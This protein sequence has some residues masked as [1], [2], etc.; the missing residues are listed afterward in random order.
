MARN[1]LEAV[2]GAL[3]GG[4]VG[5]GKDKNLR[6]DREEE[7]L[8][9]E[10]AARQREEQ[11]RLDLFNAGL[12]EETSLRKRPAT[13]RTAGAAAQAIP[14]SGTIGSAL[15]VASRQMDSNI[16]GGRRITLSDGTTY[17]QPYDR[18]PQGLAEA[19]TKQAAQMYERSRADALADA[20][21]AFE[22]DRTLTEMR[23][24]GALAVA[25][26]RDNAQAGGGGT[27]SG[28]GR[29]GVDM[30][31]LPT[32]VRAADDVAKLTREQI[33]GMDPS[34]V[35]A[36]SMA[37]L[38]AAEPSL[39]NLA[40]AGV[41]NL[42]ANRGGI[43]TGS[44]S[45][46]EPLYAQYIGGVSDAIARIGERVGVM[47]NQ[48]IARYRALTTFLPGDSDEIKL[49]KWENLRD[50][51]RFL[52]DARRV[53][54]NPSEQ[55]LSQLRERVATLGAGAS[56]AEVRQFETTAFNAW[57]DKNEPEEDES[58]EDYVARFNRDTGIGRR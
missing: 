57:A 26:A 7:R 39:G 8:A 37:P 4:L 53:A 24:A 5:Y 2:F 10:L 31:A 38:L 48:D 41:A 20:N 34:R 16:T 25:N 32:V 23:T 36:A 46:L 3:G 9:R 40:G 30:P 19:E 55:A 54:E 29:V 51:A 11:R 33:L 13:M 56:D 6:M 1:A 47:T 17:V 44:K 58:N 12:D 52:V 18:T 14:M 50:W 45:T 28:R 15:D 42:W 27:G 22:R 49:R 21:A 43:L 35:W